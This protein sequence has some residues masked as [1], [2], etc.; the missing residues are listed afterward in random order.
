MDNSLS[1]ADRPTKPAATAP[2]LVYQRFDIFERIEHILF[3]TSFTILGLTGLAQKFSASPVSLFVLQTLGGIEGTRRIHHIAAFVMMWVTVYHIIAVLYRIIVLRVR[4][5]MMPLFDDF[6]HL[7]QD[8]AY[9]LGIRKHKAFYGRYNYAEKMEYLAVVWGTIIMGI[10]GFMMWNPITTATY[11]PGE[12]IPA[13]K[14]AHGGEAILAVLAI[15]IWHMYHVHLKRF[16]KS[17]FTG[18]L[19]HEEMKEEH[20]AELELIETGSG[21]QRPSSDLI[22]RRQ[23]TFIPVAV[24]LALVLSWGVI[25]FVTVEPA[26][27]ITTVPKGETVAVFVPVTPT[28]RPTVTPKP[29]V[30]VVAGASSNS[31][32]GNYSALFSN[33]CGTCHGRTAVSGL[34]LSTY[35]GALQGGTR[36]PAIVPGN[37]DASI[38]VQV[39]SAGGHP[40]QL[41][42]DELNLVIQWILDGAPEK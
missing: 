27:A 36:G 35:L 40:G 1:A 7:A 16:N 25:Q 22:R 18:K 5:T 26:T 29:T 32:D 33:R 23:R 3:L 41:T 31:W 24:I 20:P 6:T 11:L 4:W 39:Q 28:P 10:S 30:A 21:W 37:P 15:I 2:Q 38:L 14:A 34:N 17:M 12:A 42:I 19:T 9:Y 8:V 13:A